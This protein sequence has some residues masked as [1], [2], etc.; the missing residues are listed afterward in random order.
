MDGLR[1]ENMTDLN[2]EFETILKSDIEIIKAM[3][4]NHNEFDR[5]SLLCLNI[6]AKH[7]QFSNKVNLKILDALK[8]INSDINNLNSNFCSAQGWD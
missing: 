3:A 1:G 7:I 4:K 8:D 5:N 2:Q 6:I